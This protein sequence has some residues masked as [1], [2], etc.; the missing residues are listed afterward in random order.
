MANKKHGI[1]KDL[2]NLATP[3]GLFKALP[4][5]PRRGNVQAVVKSYEKFGQRKPI[6]ARRESDDS[7]IVISGNHQLLAAI[8]LGWT[9]I[10]ASIVDEDVSVSEAFALADNRTADL[11]TYDDKALAEMLER[12][13]VDDSMLDATG[14][15][16]ADLEK[17][18]GIEPELPSEGQII[19]VLR[20]GVTAGT[21]VGEADG[22][23]TF[24]GTGGASSSTLSSGKN[25]VLNWDT[26]EASRLPN[27]A[28]TV[29]G[30]LKITNSSN[31]PEVVHH[32]RLAF[33]IL[34][35]ITA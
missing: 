26:A 25:I 20:H 34:P 9:H 10:A 29:F 17:L 27:E 30:D 22:R 19:D 3:I 14:Y 21:A 4:G 11:G 8:Q 6:V 2:E 5:N 16:L 12:V 7:L 31:P 32:I 28:I 35:E 23:I 13:A 15:D 1:I 24:V 33:D 18:L